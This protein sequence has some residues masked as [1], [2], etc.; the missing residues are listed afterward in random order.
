LIW[1]LHLLQI[2]KSKVKLL[3]RGNKKGEIK[4]QKREKKAILKQNKP[5]KPTWLLEG[6][7]LFNL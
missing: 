1:S 5:K 2:G 7:D 4:A 3:R 6:D